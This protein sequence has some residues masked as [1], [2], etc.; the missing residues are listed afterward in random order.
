MRAWILAFLLPAAALCAAER[1]ALAF[2]PPQ[3]NFGMIVR[4]A[5]VQQAV[6]VRNQGATPV[7]V[8]FIPTCTCLASEPSA[9]ALPAGA[10]GTFLLS[11]DSTDDTGNTRK[12]FI[13][14]SDPPA[15]QVLFYTLTGT[16]RA[17]SNQAG[18]TGGSGST[19]PAWVRHD[20]PDDPGSSVTATLSYYYT[21]GCRSCEEFL[22]V[23][24]PRLEKEL[25]IRIAVEKK[26]ILTTSV[27]EELSS[28]AAAR[29]GAIREL[30]VLRVGDILLQGDR[31][32]REKLA[33]A[34]KAGV[35]SQP[36]AAPG[37]PP[38]PAASAAA[39]N[40]DRF[41]IVPVLLA[42]LADGINP[43]AFT[44]LIFLLASLALA[45]RGRRDVL[46]IGAVFSL[47]V[48]LTYFGI[49]LGFFAALRAASAAPV[50]SLV[51]RWALVLVLAVFSG[52]SIYD[53]TL[54]RAGRPGEMLLQLPS[55][56][57]RRIHSSIRG[58]VRTTALVGSSLVLG[59]LVSI[60]EFA[61][62]G[63]VYLPTLGVLARLHRQADALALLALYNICFI[64]PLLVVFGAS[65]L[66]VSSGRITA[67]FQAHMGAMKLVLAAVFIGL[68]V[69]TLVG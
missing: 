69:F 15:A 53:F 18:V 9:R 24:I 34:L 19:T 8:T 66:G 51:L 47:S 36:A 64:V 55:A 32:I 56:L 33:A 63:Q 67:F 52:L 20:S 27:Y 23:E 25:G 12:D 50:V 37:T 10:E 22:S 49:G 45:G 11:Y 44:T 13:V 17:Q 54:I 42:G 62:T 4:G 57:K 43:C 6:V 39:S 68:A 41:A 65:Y 60:F 1:P 38:A 59:F 46:L 30:P 61:C 35:Q 2:S 29:G 28:L 48:F 14:R 26:D 7:T 40:A 58:R 21:P 3:W 31:E 5:R 16:V